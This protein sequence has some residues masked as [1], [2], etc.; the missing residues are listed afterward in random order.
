M[1]VLAEEI[2]DFNAPLWNYGTG[3]GADATGSGTL[4]GVSYTMTFSL[5]TGTKL[6]TSTLQHTSNAT[7]GHGGP[8][9]SLLLGGAGEGL[10]ITFA[11][12][13]TVTLGLSHVNISSDGW[14]FLTPAD[15]IVSLHSE[16]EVVGM[17][18]I[19]GFRQNT[20]LGS[21]YHRHE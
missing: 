18:S 13:V 7:L 3:N 20:A 15:E 11:S 17:A 5:N 14:D 19:D 6:F 8:I 16:H 9:G 12:P 21:N 2:T 10:S 1:T 4:G